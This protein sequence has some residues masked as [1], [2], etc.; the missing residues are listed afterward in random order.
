VLARQGQAHVTSH[1]VR[2]VDKKMIDV[3][4]DGETLGEIVIRGNTVMKGYLDDEE[5]TAAAF[6]G[7]WYHSG[8]MAAW[9]PDGYI[10]IRD[11][12]KD[13][14]ISGGENISSIEVEQTVDQHPAVLEVA[15]IAIPD[16]KWGERPK[17]FV[18]LRPGQTA[19]EQEIIEFCKSRIARYKAPAAVEILDELPKTSTGKVQK[20][21]L[22]D[23]E[24]AG[25]DKRV[26]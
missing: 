20:F 9:Q 8:D 2:V 7:G 13:V 11:R 23:K 25:H 4:R 6:A 10:E 16:D 19:T 14:I 1:L 21:V 17:A 15:V 26:G 24:W 18:A 12:S 3:P 22:R 5:A